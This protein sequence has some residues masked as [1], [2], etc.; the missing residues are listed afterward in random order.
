MR[1]NVA[2]RVWNTSKS[3]AE[4]AWVN[5]NHSATELQ[6]TDAAHIAG[7]SAGEVLRF[8]DPNP[9]GS[10]V[11]DLVALDISGYLQAQLGAVFPQA[12]VIWGFTCPRQQGRRVLPF[13][14]MAVL[15]RRSAAMRSAMAAGMGW[16]CRS[17][18]V[19]RR[20]YQTAISCSCGNMS[21]ARQ[22]TCR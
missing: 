8:G 14:P 5:W 19:N 17:G 2:V 13:L 18:R 12:G 1:G 10:N 4:V 20:Q 9:T 22:P 15:E 11:L 21:P 7:W 3:P 6:V 16:P